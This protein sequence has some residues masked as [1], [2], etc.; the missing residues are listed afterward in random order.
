MHTND[1]TKDCITWLDGALINAIDLQGGVLKFG[2]DNA[3]LPPTGSLYSSDYLIRSTVTGSQD[4]Y[5]FTLI[6]ETSPTREVVKS[7]E[8]QFTSTVQSA[9]EAGQQAAMELMPLLQTIREFEVNKRNSD[10]NVAILDL[11]TQDTPD[12]ITIKPEKTLVDTSETINVAITMLDCDGVPLGNR[13]IIFKDGT[14]S[15]DDSTK[16]IDFTGTRGGEIIPSIATTDGSGKVTVKFKAGHTEGTG[17]IV[18]WYPHFKPCGR[19]SAF[20]GTAFVQIKMPPPTLWLLKAEMINTY[21]LNSDTAKIYDLGGHPVIYEYSSIIEEQTKGKVTAVI[22]NLAEDPVNDFYYNTDALEPQAL[23][24]SGEGRM[25]EY[26]K[27]RETIDGTLSSANIRSDNVSG[28]ARPGASIFFEYS[29]DYEY[30]GVGVYIKA[31]GSYHGHMYGPHGNLNEWWDYGGDYDDYGLSAGGGGD[32]SDPNTLCWVDKEDSGYS[33]SWVI[34]EK[35]QKAS[36]EGTDYITRTGHLDATLVPY[37][38][39]TAIKGEEYDKLFPSSFSLSQ[40]F[41][42]PFNPRTNITFQIKNRELAKLKVYNLLGAEVTALV[43]EITPR[44]TYTISWDASNLPSGIY[45]YQLQ[46]GSYS[47][48][49]KMMLMK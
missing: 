38:S 17:E 19:A 23:I 37:N 21:T 24:V 22:E 3:N 46:A 25:D 30:I 45:F 4:S 42:N 44:G 16:T 6:L 27:Y 8:F 14:M 48:T 12:A 49:K 2:L 20:Q 43:N 15:W 41:P 28:L 13:K 1:P 40:N 9:N 5:I 47:E 11:W 18:G 34:Y 39:I 33:A 10:V 7:V 32:G 35:E 26:G 29:K 31:V 36:I